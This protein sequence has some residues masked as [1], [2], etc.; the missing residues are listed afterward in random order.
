MGLDN[1]EVRKFIA[2]WV[3]W[4]L[5]QDINSFLESDLYHKLRKVLGKKISTFFNSK[6]FRSIIYELAEKTLN[7]NEKHG[8]TFKKILPHGFENSLKVL[9]YNKSPQI[10][11][12]IKRY[13]N[14][15]KFKNL[16]KSEV[17]KLLVS[18]NPMVAKFIN[19]DSIQ[20]KIMNSLNSFFDN[21]DNIMNIVTFLNNKIDDAGNK[22]LSELL[23]YMPY[24]GKSDIVKAAADS[25]LNLFNSKEFIKNVQILV[26]NNI[27]AYDTIGNFMNAMG[28]SEEELLH[29]IDKNIVKYLDL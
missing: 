17:N 16:V 8:K 13:I 23:N 22:Q 11:S 29:I 5:N 20:T 9:V 28:F 27:L 4:N 14:D 12:A 1:K 7:D 24:E 25:I 26:Y 15:I 21:T 19:G 18:L 2:S 10:A 3:K 6:E